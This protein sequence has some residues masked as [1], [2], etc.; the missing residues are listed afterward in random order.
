M[1]WISLRSE[2]DLDQLIKDSESQVQAIF[3]H[4]TRCSISSIARH[5]LE[6]D[7][8]DK[9]PQIPIHYLDLIQYRELSNEIAKRFGVRHESPQLILVQNGK[10]LF[11]NSHLAI[12]S[13][14]AA[15]RIEN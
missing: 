3:K 4:S 9:L 13:K 6:S 15:K 10:V 7:W 2:G 14:S 11:H 5:R 12:S 8:Q 1:N